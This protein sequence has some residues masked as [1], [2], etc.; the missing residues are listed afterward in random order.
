MKVYK[1][2]LHKDTLAL[3]EASKGRLKRL[4]SVG[5][6]KPATPTY[7]IEESIVKHNVGISKE[8]IQAWVW[9]R[10][11]MGVPME[12]WK[13]YHVDM[14]QE[15]LAYFVASGFLFIDPIQNGYVP[16]PVF[17]FGNMY[18]KIDRLAKIR[19]HVIENHGEAV[20]I[21][22]LEVLEANKPTPLSIQNPIEKERPIILAISEFTGE[23]T[24]DSLKLETGVI[25]E[26]ASTLKQAYIKWLRSLDEE[27][28]HHTNAREITKYYLRNSRKP[29]DIEK[30][31]WRELKKITR[32]EGERLFKE[33]LHTALTITDQLRID[34]YYNSHYNAIAPLQH[35]KIPIAI[36]VSKKFMGLDLDIRAAQREGIAFMEL[37]GSGIIAYDVGVG[38]TI[39]AIIET[40]SAILNGKCKRPL[41][42][43]PNS[44]YGNWLNEML[45]LSDTMQ[46]ILTG[47]NI[48]V[49]K[50]FNLGSDYSYLDFSKK[51]PEKSITLITYQG[52]EKIGF[53]QRTQD[54]HFMHL[55]DILEQN[56]HKSKR[57]AE[58][59]YE[60]I[61]AI[62]GVGL[63]NTVADIE[64]L[65]IDYIVIDEAHNFKNIFADV[66]G[67]QKNGKYFHI[68]GSTSE[69][70]IKA[71]FLC[72]Y[73]QRTYGR[74]VMLLTATPFTNSP[75]EIYSML[76][77]VA[78][79]YMRSWGIYN[80]RT[81][82]EQ[83]IQETTDNVITIEGK[84]K[85]K[86]I[87]KSFNNRVS[88]QK[89]I[90]SH[91]N[92]KTGEEADIPRPCKINLPKTSQQTDKGIQPLPKDKQLLTYLKM[93]PTQQAFQKEFNSEA[94]KGASQT[95]PNRLL[96]LLNK[97]LNNALSP[98]LNYGM[99]KDFIDF[100][101]SAPKIKYTMECI[102]SVKK[103]Y[104][105]RSLPMSGQ[106]IYMNRGKDFF[107]YIK[108][109]LEVVVGFQKNRPLKSNPRKKVDE[110]EFIT[111]DISTAKK[112]KIKQAFN[113]G[114]CKVIIGTSA[115]REGINLQKK[116]TDLYNLYPDWNPTDL[117]Q[118]EGRIWRQKNENA[119]V[120]ITMPLME[121]S[122]DIFV[123]QKLEEKTARIND[124]WSKA[125]RGNVLDEE[126]LNPNEIKYALITDTKVLLSFELNELAFD[127]RSKMSFLNKRIADIQTFDE[128]KEKYTSLKEKLIKDVDAAL[129][130]LQ[131]IEIHTT[132]ERTIYFYE[133]VHINAED[134]PKAA[135]QKVKR[136]Q[137][138]QNQLIQLTTNG[139]ED[140]LLLQTLSKYYKLIKLYSNPYYFEAF[141][142]TV[143]KFKKIEKTLLTVG[144]DSK[145]KTSEILEK[146]EQELKATQ[147]EYEELSTKEFQ[148][149]LEDKIK[150]EKQKLSVVGADFETRVKEFEKL[151]HLLSYKFNEVA[152]DTCSIPEEENPKLATK[153]KRIKIAKAKA[154]ALQLKRK[155][156]A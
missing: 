55:A 104:E 11:Q 106:V 63:K 50:W 112:E 124:I 101:D 117:R 120:R 92:Y 44:T 128:I 88:L 126:S 83:Y 59:D 118:V 9:Y 78:Y 61:R 57:E 148:D 77:L 154:I 1:G 138:L 36:E 74:N 116:A 58:K 28:I 32:N 130:R 31:A 111:G 45:G 14:T 102:A 18:T 38:K 89:L 27:E 76:S 90:N 33:F 46:G 114:V 8:E 54:E 98:Y 135:A 67:D 103:W 150:E 139:F 17:V 49:N 79:E 109:Y 156:A 71:F 5:L 75:M 68:T 95:D 146:F 4:I 100:I 29:M 153:I 81:F 99:P 129:N 64:D 152:Q 52:L 121:N 137:E 7:T 30:I 147:T 122:M 84:I 16:F 34:A 22:H 39:T 85:S 19:E 131:D 25:I 37:I 56:T 119:F 133:M 127:L 65:G 87:V 48:T 97:S 69:R 141:K 149:R 151:N 40:A 155:R 66:K 140:V 123:F 43:V 108:E 86:N 21:N 96:R 143:S 113:E 142:E 10:R 42:V 134:L 24:V 41:I 132:L 94:S 35:H 23:F 53:N 26:E 3:I 70:G 115:I 125:N 20:F 51:V 107:K 60:R 145:A 13:A 105:K 110:V 73:I 15:R 144:L 82:F 80:I 2:S 12:N 47:T 93:T 62:I 136:L 91:I 6:G 72:N